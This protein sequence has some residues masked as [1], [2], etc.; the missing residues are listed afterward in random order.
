HVA[1]V[2]PFAAQHTWLPA[3]AVGM[4][5]PVHVPATHAPDEQKGAVV[6]YVPSALHSL[7]VV[8]VAHLLS[9]VQ[10]LPSMQ[11][12]LVAQS[13][14]THAPVLKKN[15]GFV[16]VATD[17]QSSFFVHPPHWLFRQTCPLAQFG[18]LLGSFVE[19]HVAGTHE[20]LRHSAPC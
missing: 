16:V 11:S 13:P 14:G 5:E 20:P 7:S 1:G 12:A 18:W 17:A 15:F 9:V 6:A 2:P 10:I 4:A 3:H 8:Q 19:R